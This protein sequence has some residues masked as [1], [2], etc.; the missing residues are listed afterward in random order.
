MKNLVKQI[1]ETIKNNTQIDPELFKKHNVKRGLRNEDHTGVVVGLTKVGDV[2]GYE[3]N[4]DGTT[5]AIPDD[6]CTEE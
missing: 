3:R 5:R 1:S 4:E 6:Y 2:Q